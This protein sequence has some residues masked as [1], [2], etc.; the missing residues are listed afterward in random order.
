MGRSFGLSFFRPSIWSSATRTGMP[1]SSDIRSDTTSPRVISTRTTHFARKRYLLQ[2]APV[3]PPRATA[4]PAQN[5]SSTLRLREA[6]TAVLRPLRRPTLSKSTAIPPTNINNVSTSGCMT[7]GSTNATCPL[8]GPTLTEPYSNI[9]DPNSTERVCSGGLQNR[10]R[11]RLRTEW[12]R[13]TA[14]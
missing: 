7:S 8:Y 10:E 4:S 12:Q 6:V 13:R 2:L 3:S 9:H 1:V 5:G 11:N 14:R